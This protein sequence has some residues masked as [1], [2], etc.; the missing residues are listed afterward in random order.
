VVFL[1]TT[2]SAPDWRW[3]QFRDSL[4]ERLRGSYSCSVPDQREEVGLRETASWDGSESW[5]LACTSDRGSRL[6]KRP[7]WSAAV[8]LVAA[9]TALRLDGSRS[10]I[11]QAEGAAISWLRIKGVMMLQGAAS[12]SET[13]ALMRARSTLEPATLSVPWI[14]LIRECLPCL[15]SPLTASSVKGDTREECLTGLVVALS[16]SIAMSSSH[17]SPLEN[18]WGCSSCLERVVRFCCSSCL[19]RSFVSFESPRGVGSGMGF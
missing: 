5:M 10:H 13:H 12:V 1:I 2:S 9:A 8:L 7:V 11:A 19:A 16:V 17:C 4:I 3:R 18:S 14:S 6:L 15:S